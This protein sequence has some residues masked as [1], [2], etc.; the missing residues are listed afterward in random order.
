MDVKEAGKWILDNFR[1]RNDLQKGLWI[2]YAALS[3]YMFFTVPTS[4]EY[5]WYIVISIPTFFFLDWLFRS[6]DKK[7]KLM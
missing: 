3:V 2:I 4:Y 7:N 5:W 6:R 1:Q